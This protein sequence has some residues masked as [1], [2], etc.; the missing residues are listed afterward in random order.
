MV[1]RFEP[2]LSENGRMI[3]L[4]SCTFDQCERL[5]SVLSDKMDAA[6]AC[7]ASGVDQLKE[8]LDQVQARLDMYESGSI[9]KEEE[10]KRSFKGLRAEDDPPSGDFF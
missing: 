1:R 7:G 3:P 2:H 5:F 10:K 6:I 9:K 4:S 8:F